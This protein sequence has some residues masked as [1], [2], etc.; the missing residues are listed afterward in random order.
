MSIP[1][2]VSTPSSISAAIEVWT[3]V[4]AEKPSIEVALMSELL[5]A[6]TGTIK[7]EKGIFST[8]LKSVFYS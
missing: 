5:S 6:W 1:F 4:I 8:S 2:E 3:W 7:D